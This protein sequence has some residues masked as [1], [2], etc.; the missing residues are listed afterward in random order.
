MKTINK[1]R[2]LRLELTVLTAAVLAIELTKIKLPI[3]EQER[4][5]QHG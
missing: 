4:M 2:N 1:K 5:I 3:A